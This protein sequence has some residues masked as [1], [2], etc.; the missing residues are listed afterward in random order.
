MAQEEVT[1]LIVIISADVE[2]RHLRT[3]LT[4][5]RLRLTV[6]LTNQSL[7]TEPTELQVRLNTKQRLAAANQR[8][9]QIERHVTGFNRLNN[10]I[11]LT[12]VIQLQVLLVEG[13]RRLSIVTQIEIELR[14]YLTL[15]TGLDLLIKI[16]DVIIAR[17]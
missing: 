1:V 9:R 11:L 13:E 8:R 6:L 16:E 4:A 7:N 17:A 5:Y 15:D 14:T 2:F 10:I 3:A 12:L